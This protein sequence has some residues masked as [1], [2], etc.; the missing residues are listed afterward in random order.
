M[1][2]KQADNDILSQLYNQPKRVIGNPPPGTK[3][4]NNVQP[5]DSRSLQHLIANKAVNG[6]DF[7]FI[8]WI[9]FDIALE[10]DT[11]LFE[12]LA[13]LSN[14]ENSLLSG[15]EDGETNF[16]PL[17]SGNSGPND[18]FY[19]VSRDQGVAGLNVITND[20]DNHK[21]KISYQ[22]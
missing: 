4:Y 16:I 3:V 1:I 9:D 15:N 7:K 22:Q 13:A 14:F 10:S 5:Y 18:Y 19:R 17:A 12:K 6:D 21:E 11:Q 2:S 8:S 20:D